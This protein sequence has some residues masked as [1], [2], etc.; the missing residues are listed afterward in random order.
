M[1]RHL[2][3]SSHSFPSQVLA[4][5]A[6]PSGRL[7]R[8]GQPEPRLHRGG[9]RHHAGI[10]F[11]FGSCHPWNVTIPSPGPQEL[12]QRALLV[13]L[14]RLRLLLPLPLRQDADLRP[15]REAA[16]A[17]RRRRRRRRSWR[18]RLPQAGGQP[19]PA[20]Q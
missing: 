17:G 19:N 9:G 6:R 10:I 16:A 12:P 13:R 15:L 7:R 5:P 2:Q 18:E 14:R 1:F 11:F 4:R 8:P 20:A 3:I